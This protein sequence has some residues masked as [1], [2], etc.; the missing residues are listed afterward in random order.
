[1]QV[2]TCDLSVWEVRQEDQEFKLSL[3]YKFTWRPPWATGNKKLICTLSQSTLQQAHKVLP[4]N[5]IMDSEWTAGLSGSRLLSLRKGIT[6]SPWQDS[7]NRKQKWGI[8]ARNGTS[9]CLRPEAGKS[10]QKQQLER[11]VRLHSGKGRPGFHFPGEHLQVDCHFHLLH[12][13]ISVSSESRTMSK[14]ASGRSDTAQWAEARGPW[15]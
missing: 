2:N 12:T 7:Q 8:T 1:M 9:W 14:G 15:V 4:S 10:E 3:G 5:S 11:W 13:R 6:K